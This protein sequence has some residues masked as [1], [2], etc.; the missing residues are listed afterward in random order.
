M[1]INF[2]NNLAYNYLNTYTIL[3]GGVITSIGTTTINNNLANYGFGTPLGSINGNNFSGGSEVNYPN[4]A[5]INAMTQMETLQQAIQAALTGAGGAAQVFPTPVA[6]AITL[7]PNII[8][9]WFATTTLSLNG[10]TI[11]FNGAG[12]YIII[13]LSGNGISLKNCNFNYT[14]VDP[15]TI[16]WS[17][18]SQIT[19]NGTGTTTQVPGIFLTYG[20]QNGDNPTITTTS[21]TINGN[22]YAGSYPFQTSTTQGAITLSGTTLNSTVACFLKGTKILTDRGYFPIEELQIEDKV[23]TYGSIID[24]SKV[25][26]N[27]KNQTSPIKWIGK[28]NT[29]RH[30]A[31]DLPVCFKVGSLGENLP[32][33]DLFVSP[34]QRV[35][36]DGQMVVAGSIVN[37]ETIVQ[38][39]INGPIEYFHFELDCHSVIM[40]EGVLSETFLEL[41][42]S[43]RSFR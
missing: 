15:S 11:T 40:A 17:A 42:G 34:G 9:Y 7:N 16:F 24:N 13:T 32:E 22:L 10:V 27:G 29:Y 28:Y 30:D 18:P 20:V 12:Q 31:Y 37:G 3:G 33:N 36:I 25:V 39:D 2:L 21:I 26:L 23:I 14:G 38:E 8:Y 19:L 35:I 6:N 5:A 1:S 41:D 43:K 4:Q